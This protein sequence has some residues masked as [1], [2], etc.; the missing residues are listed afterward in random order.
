MGGNIR[1]KLVGLRPHSLNF[2]KISSWKDFL[3]IFLFWLPGG[4]N[5][6]FSPI[7]LHTKS[8]VKVVKRLCRRFFRWKLLTILFREILFVFLEDI[9]LL[10]NFK[11]PW[12]KHRHNLYSVFF[13]KVDWRK[14]WIF[15][16][17]PPSNQK[18][19]QNSAKK[20]SKKNFSRRDFIKVKERGREANQLP[21]I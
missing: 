3:I 5:S 4:K 2:Y 18:K 15:F 9:F 7:D 6:I 1:R 13:V 17:L 12:K 20:N 8:T 19:R 11:R 16:N 14:N 21:Q 10:M